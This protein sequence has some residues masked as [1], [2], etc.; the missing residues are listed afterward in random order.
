MNLTRPDGPQSAPTPTRRGLGAI[1]MFA[2]YAAAVNPV[3]GAA[4]TTPADG[5][6]TGMVSY[7]S[8]GFDLPAFVARPSGRGRKPVVIVV[9]EI[10]GLHE[11][12]RDMF[13]ASWLCGCCARVFCPRR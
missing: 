10:F 8:N 13:S 4:I 1:A 7:P 2:G 11:Y 5:L 9:S 6:V 3:H 12:I